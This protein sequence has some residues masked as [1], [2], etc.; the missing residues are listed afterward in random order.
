MAI[1]FYVVEFM[2]NSIPRSE[3]VITG[4]PGHRDYDFECQRVLWSVHNSRPMCPVKSSALHPL[5]WCFQFLRNLHLVILCTILRYSIPIVRI[6]QPGPTWQI[7]YL[8]LIHGSRRH[9]PH[10][11]FRAVGDRFRGLIGLLANTQFNPLSL[12]FCG[13]SAKD[14]KSSD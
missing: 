11:W 8:I 2:I 14:N 9:L 1:S 5:I 10:L 3:P 12:R 4:T 6:C 13:W 7:T